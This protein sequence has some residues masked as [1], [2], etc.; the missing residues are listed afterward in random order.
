MRKPLKW[1]FFLSDISWICAFLYK[2]K[3]MDL[4]TVKKPNNLRL[5]V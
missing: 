5:M 4:I 1:G 2:M 3:P